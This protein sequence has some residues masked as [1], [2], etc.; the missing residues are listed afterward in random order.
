M[1]SQKK[2]PT[3]IYEAKLQRVGGGLEVG[4][5]KSPAL[6]QK[7]VAASCLYLCVSVLSETNRTY[8]SH[9]IPLCTVRT[10]SCGAVVCF[11]MHLHTVSLYLVAEAAKG[12]NLVDGISCG[13]LNIGTN[14]ST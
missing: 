9:V 6:D 4:T 8:V 2:K 7:S 14:N 12:R 10:V 1:S 13:F 5:R 11:E 3:G